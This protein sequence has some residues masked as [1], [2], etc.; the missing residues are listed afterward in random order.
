MG[1]ILR[2]ESFEK[3]VAGAEVA[4]SLTILRTLIFAPGYQ[5]DQMSLKKLPKM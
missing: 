1:R 4:I 5:G 3:S 2:K